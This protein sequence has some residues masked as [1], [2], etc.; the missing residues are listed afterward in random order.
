MFN[1]FILFVP[2]VSVLL[3]D[4]GFEN[5]YLAVAEEPRGRNSLKGREEKQEKLAAAL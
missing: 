4:T 3:A 5:G 2:V 1:K